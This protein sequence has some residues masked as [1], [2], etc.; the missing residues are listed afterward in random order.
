MKKSFEKDFSSIIQIN[1][2][3]PTLMLRRICKNL[4]LDR[5]I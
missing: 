1:S 3:N 4:S 5:K 2:L